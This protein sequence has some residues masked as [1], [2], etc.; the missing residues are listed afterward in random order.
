MEDVGK[1]VGLVV[2]GLVV[3]RVGLR[4]VV[5]EGCLVVVDVVVGLVGVKVVVEELVGSEEGRVVINVVDDGPGC[6]VV[7]VVVVSVPN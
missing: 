3:E 4:V 1:F 5:L 6:I 7:G 2:V